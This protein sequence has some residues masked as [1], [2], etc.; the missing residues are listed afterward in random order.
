MSFMATLKEVLGLAPSPKTKPCP[1][2]QDP[3]TRLSSRR[4][5][6]ALDR[7]FMAAERTLMAW[8]RTSLSMISFGFTIGKL[9]EVLGATSVKLAFGRTTGIAGV[10]YFLVILGTFALFVAAVQN[11]VVVVRLFRMGLPRRFSLAFLNAIL[12]GLLGAFAFT[13]LVIEL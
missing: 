7:N 13:S 10:A 11:R 2:L 8:I 9:G 1:D 4:T 5:D 6:L 3:S 12:L